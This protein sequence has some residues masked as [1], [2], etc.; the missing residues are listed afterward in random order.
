MIACMFERGIG[1]N[2]VPDLQSASKYFEMAGNEGHVEAASRLGHILR[3]NGSAD[4]DSWLE[5]AAQHGDADAAY[6]LGLTHR[7]KNATLAADWFK[8]AADRGASVVRAHF[9]KFFRDLQDHAQAQFA[10]GVLIR[11]K[12]PIA[13]AVLFERAG[14]QGYTRALLNLATQYQIGDG[15]PRQ[16]RFVLLDAKSNILPRRN[17]QRALDLYKQA[18]AA[19]EVNAMIELAKRLPDLKAARKWL[20]KASRAGS[21]LADIMLGAEKMLAAGVT[22]DGKSTSHTV[23]LGLEF[24]SKASALVARG[25]TKFYRR[26]RRFLAMLPADAF[27]TTAAAAGAGVSGTAV[28]REFKDGRKV[29]NVRVLQWSDP[30]QLGDCEILPQG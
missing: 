12:D 27:K 20:Q 29:R 13:A 23:T 2:G 19:G 10:L 18:A 17:E 6:A 1:V 28:T 25:D 9:S 16:A 5:F 22:G 7:A 3:E 21:A 26:D 30:N 4:A 8:L 11:G 14:E 15:V 24:L